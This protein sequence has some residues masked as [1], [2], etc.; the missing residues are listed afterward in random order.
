MMRSSFDVIIVG[1][2]AAGCVLAGRLSANPAIQVLLIEAGADAPPGEEHPAIRDPW[3]L[4]RFYP[5]FGWPSLVAEVGVDRGDGLPR[6][7]RPFLQGRGVGGTSNINGMIALRGLPE[8]YDEW[9]D[10]GAAG[11]GWN[12][13]LPYFRALEDDLDFNGPDHGR[14]GPIPIRR[15]RPSD[16]A[17]LSRAFAEAVMARGYPLVED[18][19]ADFRDGIGPIPNSNFADRRVSASMGYLDKRTRERSNLCILADALVERVECTGKRVTGVTATVAGERKTFTAREIIISAGALHS[20]AVLMRS[21]IGAGSHLKEQGIDVVADLSGV[22]RNLLN[23]PEMSVAMYLPRKSMQAPAQ[24][25]IGQNCLRYSSGEAGCGKG[26]M[27]LMAVNKTSWH[28]LG[29]RIGALGLTV[30]QSYSVGN[31]RLANRDATIEP[32]VTFNLLSDPRD[33]NRLVSGLKLCF[34][35]LSGPHMMAARNEV[36]LPRGRLV[37]S[38]SKPGAW[39]SFRAAFIT[40]VFDGPPGIRQTLLGASKLKPEILAGDPDSLRQLV[41][42]RAQPVFHV[43]GTCRMGRPGATDIVVDSDCA[44]VGVDGLRVI[45]ASIMP[46]MVRANTHLPVLMIAEKMASFIADR[47]R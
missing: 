1:A 26:D 19:N 46:S 39:N 14:A 35:I 38:L 25:A 5:Q 8:D 40:A 24:R 28:A 6:A 29:Q 41:I 9:R 36:F 27:L 16:Y 13:V 31:V 3:P 22:G 17:P 18:M 33:F 10:S 20:P 12:D 4:S 30:F 21:G 11:W 23:H 45:D 44:V 2:G 42:D 37:Q 7:S 47:L 43:G 32:N 34:E 15:I